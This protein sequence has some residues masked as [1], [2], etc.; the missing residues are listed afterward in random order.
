MTDHGVDHP[1]H[2]YGRS[3]EHAYGDLAEEAIAPG[4]QDDIDHEVD[5]NEPGGEAGMT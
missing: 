3:Q 1:H 5:A 4:Q 2:E